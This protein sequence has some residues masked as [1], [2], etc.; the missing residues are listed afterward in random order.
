MTREPPRGV[1]PLVLFAALALGAALLLP[2]HS[3]GDERS[4]PGGDDVACP[5]AAVAAPR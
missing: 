1:S 3:S 4:G 2:A 5:P